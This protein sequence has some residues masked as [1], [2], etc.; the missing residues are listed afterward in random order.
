MSA[1]PAP[2]REEILT[3]Q[4]KNTMMHLNGQN[5]RLA[6]KN[7]P[8]SKTP[9]LHLSATHGKEAVGQ[10]TASSLTQEGVAQLDSLLLKSPRPDLEK[11]KEAENQPA[12]RP[13]KLAPLQLPEEVK[14]AQKQKIKFIEQ[15]AKDVSD[16]LDMA[17]N[18]PRKVKACVRHRQVKSPGRPSALSEP[19]KTQQ[20]HRAP[21]AKLIR[22][23]PIEQNSERHLE[24]VV[25]R[26]TPALLCSK[27]TPP[28]VSPGVKAQ[29]TRSGEVASQSPGMLQQQTGRR[30]LRL[31]RTQRLEEDQGKSNTSTG[32]LSG[33][34][35]KLAQGFQGKGQRAERALREASRMLEKA[36][37]RNLAQQHP[38]NMAVSG[39]AMRRVAVSDLQEAVL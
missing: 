11:E 9:G 25:C 26:G 16:K 38:E 14:E 39:R 27:P 23:S 15:E 17:V 8:N 36:S 5:L 10:L 33:D 32:G 35:G 1:K 34:E 6:A 28:S 30:R 22:S 7:G 3:S 2:Q 37:K 4:G 12:R 18:G 24:E 20:Q 21:R 13:M 29:A 31:R 19:V